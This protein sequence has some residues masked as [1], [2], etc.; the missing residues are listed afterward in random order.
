MSGRRL[1]QFRL[2]IRT[3]RLS[4]P[5]TRQF[6]SLQCRR[7]H[8]VHQIQQALRPLRTLRLHLQSQKLRRAWRPPEKGGHTAIMSGGTSAASIPARQITAGIIN[9]GRIIKATT[10]ADTFEFGEH[11]QPRGCFSAPTR[12]CSREVDPS[13]ARGSAP[14]DWAVIDLPVN[15]SQ[16]IFSR[17]KVDPA[18]ITLP[19][20]K[21]TLSR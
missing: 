19:W 11:Y 20:A 6:S 15:R 17:R 4:R 21:Q 1:P 5:Q 8:R 7:C 12:L 9:R 10:R 2:V 16:R 13:K 14:Q 18:K 3:D